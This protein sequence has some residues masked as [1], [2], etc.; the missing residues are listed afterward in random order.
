MR[1]HFEELLNKCLDSDVHNLEMHQEIRTFIEKNIPESLYRYRS[2]NEH[3]ISALKNDELWMSQPKVM[4]DFWDSVARIGKE[5]IQRYINEL[6]DDLMEDIFKLETNINNADLN[7]VHAF[8]LDKDTFE[9]G[10]K[11]ISTDPNIKKSSIDLIR[12]RS[13]RRLEY[14]ATQLISEDITKVFQKLRNVACFTENII[15]NKMWG[16]YADAHRGFAVEYRFKDIIKEC[17]KNCTICT[18]AFMNIPIFPVIYKGLCNMSKLHYYLLEYIFVSSF[19]DDIS[20]YKFKGNLLMHFLMP[21]LY[22][23]KEWEDELEWRL[24]APMGCGEDETGIYT[25]ISLA[26]SAIYCGAKISIE[27]KE[28]LKKISSDKGIQLYII[29]PQDDKLR[30]EL[31]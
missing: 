21:Y 10:L 17:K 18:N 27:N 8:G 22:K 30:Y 3:N 11:V 5:D 12:E 15:S 2:F 13:K 23:K 14:Y 25:K 28:L 26:P 24:H 4:N 7:V 9:R 6:L 1:K 16:L 29:K 19:Y 31:V 20:T